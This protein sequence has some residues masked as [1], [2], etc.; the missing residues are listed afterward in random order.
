MGQEWSGVVS[1]KAQRE[2]MTLQGGLQD[3]SLPHNV[4]VK[5][6]SSL[7]ELDTNASQ[8]CFSDFLHTNDHLSDWFDLPSPNPHPYST[9][10]IIVPIPVPYQ[11]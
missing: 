9:L 7:F 2:Y 3:Y 8:A 4:K 6:I 5:V 1:A 10:R 11:N